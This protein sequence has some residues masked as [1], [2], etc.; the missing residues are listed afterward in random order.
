[1]YIRFDFIALLYYAHKEGETWNETNTKMLMFQVFAKK[2]IR[3][4]RCN[5]S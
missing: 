2:H 3:A 4:E 5:E 1:M